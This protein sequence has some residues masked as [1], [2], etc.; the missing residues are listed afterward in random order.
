MRE[1]PEDHRRTMIDE[2]PTFAWSCGTDGAMEFLN[3]RWLD[4]TGLS[5]E[6]AIG[7][8]WKAS[9]HPDDLGQLMKAWLDVLVSQEPLQKEARLRRFDGEYRWFLFCAVPVC[10]KFRRSSDGMAQTLTSRTSSVARPSLSETS[11]SAA[12]LSM[13]YRRPSSFWRRMGPGSTAIK[14][15]SN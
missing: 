14:L 4:F 9:I 8:G 13:P 15:P 12:K 6:Q 1:A 2:I 7:W 5:M 11:L 10:N 3:Q